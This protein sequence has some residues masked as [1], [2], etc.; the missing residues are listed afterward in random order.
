MLKVLKSL[1]GV[2]VEWSNCQANKDHLLLFVLLY[3]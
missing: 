1:L 3:L 2:H